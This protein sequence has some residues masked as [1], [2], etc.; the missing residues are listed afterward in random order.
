[1]KLCLHPPMNNKPNCK[2]LILTLF[3]D[4]CFCLPN[5]GQ[6]WPFLA[7]GL[8]QIALQSVAR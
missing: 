3:T 1:M 6:M 8:H 2:G 5:A 7:R 4:M